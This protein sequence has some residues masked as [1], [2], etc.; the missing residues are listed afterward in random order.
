M[1]HLRPIA[2]VE[3]DDGVREAIRDLLSSAEFR[4]QAFRAAEGFLR[5]KSIRRFACLIVDAQLP[6]MGGSALC[7]HLSMRGIAIPTILISADEEGCRRAS[8][9]RSPQ[10]LIAVLA[11]PFDGRKFLRAVRAALRSAR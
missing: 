10:Q 7:E 8:T 1:T 9:G 6:G 11:K 5:S 4:S 2:V 3:D